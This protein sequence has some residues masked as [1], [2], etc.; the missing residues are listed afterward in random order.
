MAADDTSGMLRA[1]IWDAETGMV[2]LDLPD[3]ITL[4]DINDFGVVVGNW[5][6]DGWYVPFNGRRTAAPSSWI[7]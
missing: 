7:G 4:N 5:L 2:A 6:S 1:F 3:Y